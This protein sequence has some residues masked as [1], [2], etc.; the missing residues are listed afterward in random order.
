MSVLAQNYIGPQG[1]ARQYLLVKH[2][3]FL[4]PKKKQPKVSKSLQARD[5]KAL[6]ARS[7][8]ARLVALPAALL[9]MAL[10]S[11]LGLVYAGRY[12][13][14]LPG[15]GKE[16]VEGEYIV[17]FDDDEPDPKGKAHGLEMKYQLFRTDENWELIK[18]FAFR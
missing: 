8:R 18:G 13:E 3:A 4:H 10:V 5:F 2:K 9:L 1:P 14:P 17:L 11:F 7:F 15:K 6:M 16:L 12:E